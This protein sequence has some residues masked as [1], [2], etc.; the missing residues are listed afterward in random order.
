M[1]LET[2]VHVCDILDQLQ[3]CFFGGPRLQA[4][5]SSTPDMFTEQRILSTAL[6]PFLDYLNTTDSD[7]YHLKPGMVFKGTGEGHLRPLAR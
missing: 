2:A 1:G 5:V 4:E 7:T 6:K 3:P